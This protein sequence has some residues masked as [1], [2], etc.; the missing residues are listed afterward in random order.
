[1]CWKGYGE[2][3]DGNVEGLLMRLKHKEIQQPIPARRVYIPKNEKEKRP[4][5]ISAL[6]NKIV[7]LGNNT[8]FAKHL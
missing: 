8:D 6:R 2:D 7:E 4:L 1:M 5:G 3:L